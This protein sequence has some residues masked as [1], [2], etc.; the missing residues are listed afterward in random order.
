MTYT[1][2]PHDVR[3]ALAAADA[4]YDVAHSELHAAIASIVT[5]RTSSTPSLSAFTAVEARARDA[6][7]TLDSA[8]NALMDA[9]ENA[10]T[11]MSDH[12]ASRA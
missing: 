7:A 8:Y 9:R 3:D 10:L 1:L 5:V 2:S 4:A 6:F 12:D 11:I